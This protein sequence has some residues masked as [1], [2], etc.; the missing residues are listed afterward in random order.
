MNGM[1]NRIRPIDEARR[2]WHQR[3]LELG[4]ELRS[5]RVIGGASQAD[6]G[7][8]IG[9]S[10]S[11][12][13]RRERGEA[14]YVTAQSLQQH[15]AAVG[16][17]M[18]LTLH[19]IGGRVRDSAQLAYVHRFLER[20]STE[21][22]RELEAVIALPGDPRAVDIVLRASGCLI[23]IEIITRLGD[24]QAQLRVARIKARDIGA[25]RL[26]I[27]VAATHA[28]RRALDAAR[29]ALVGAWDLDTRRVL[30]ALAAGR[31]PDNDAIVLI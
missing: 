13:S 10:K 27:G 7:A 22:A 25:T 9:V 2:A 21:F 12:V 6:V 4:A 14:P 16:L 30:A 15:A 29:P 20:V 19:P 3:R 26:I 28:N 24:V 1:A 17:R 5:Q 11:E 8:A 23:A 18:S 31:Q